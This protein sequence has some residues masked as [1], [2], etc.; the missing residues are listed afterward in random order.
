MDEA[1]QTNDQDGKKKWMLKMIKSAKAKHKLCPYFDKKTAQ[2]FLRLTMKNQHGKC[3]RDGRFDN[4]P[5]LLEFLE[6]VYDDF[7]SKK[8]SLPNNFQDIVNLV[9]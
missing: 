5:I 9:L 4:C 3:D 8:K 6:R 1:K 7:S 2:C